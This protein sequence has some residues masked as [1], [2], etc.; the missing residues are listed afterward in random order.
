[1]Y[2]PLNFY[3]WRENSNQ[4]NGIS[5]QQLSDV[6]FKI[7]ACKMTLLIYLGP[8][9]HSSLNGNF[10][11]FDTHWCVFVTSLFFSNLESV[12]KNGISFIY[13]SP[14]VWDFWRVQI[15]LHSWGL[16]KKSHQI[17]NKYHNIHIFF[18]IRLKQHYQVFGHGQLNNVH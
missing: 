9:K 14:I 3:F 10:A 2:S 13:T 7:N 4:V 12:S 18:L 5:C 8:K 1:M 15:G 11:L 16:N 17:K 6:C